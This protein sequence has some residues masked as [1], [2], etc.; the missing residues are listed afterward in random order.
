MSKKILIIFDFKLKLVNMLRKPHFN[1]PVA[2]LAFIK[3]SGKKIAV[4][5][6]VLALQDCTYLILYDYIDL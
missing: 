3:T 6:K 2:K 5:S 4:D 1:I